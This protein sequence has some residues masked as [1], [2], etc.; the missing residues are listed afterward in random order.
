MLIFQQTCYLTV[1]VFVKT[2]RIPDDDLFSETIVGCTA[3]YFVKTMFTMNFVHPFH[4]SQCIDLIAVAEG[5]LLLD[6]GWFV[7]FTIFIKIFM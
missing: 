3:S 5:W 4:L 2:I 6:I 7:L 1:P